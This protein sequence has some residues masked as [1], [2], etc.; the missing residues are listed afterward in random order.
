MKKALVISGVVV[1]LGAVACSAPSSAPSDGAAKEE[2]GG[3]SGADIP[4]PKAGT[5]QVLI[6]VGDSAIDKSTIQGY[7]VGAQELKVEQTAAGDLYINNIPPGKED[8]IVTAGTVAVA[9]LTSQP[10]GIRESGI[11]LKDGGQAK[12]DLP[13]IPAAGSIKGFATLTGQTDHAGIDV[14]IPGTTYIAKTASDGSFEISRVPVGKH[15]LYFDKDGYGRGINGLVEVKP[16]AATTIPEMRLIL[17]TG[18]N[19]TILL[20]GGAAV[21]ASLTVEVNVIASTDAVLMMLSEDVEFKN[22]AWS[23]VTTFTTYTFATG[24]AKTLYARFA[25]ANGLETTPVSDT[26][27]IDTAGPAGTISLNS[28]AAY[29]G[30]LSATVTVDVTDEFSTVTKMRLGASSDLSGVAWKAYAGTEPVT[31]SSGDGTKTIYAQFMDGYENVSAVLSDAITLDMTAPTITT[32]TPAN[33]ATAV[34]ADA[35]IVIRPSEA[36]AA[37]TVTGANVNLKQGST[38]IAVALSIDGNGDLRLNPSAALEPFTVYTVTATTGLTDLAGNPLAAQSVTTFTTAHFW[39]AEVA[40]DYEHASFDKVLHA[41]MSDGDILAVWF[42]NSDLNYARYDAQTGWGS[43]G[44]VATSVGATAISTALAACGDGSA[45]LVYRPDPGGSIVAR[46]FASGSWSGATTIGSTVGAGGGDPV[47]VGCSSA[48]GKGI[49]AWWYHDGAMSDD[50]VR[51]ATF[52]GTTWAAATAISDTSIAF[53]PYNI[54]VAVD[55]TGKGVVVWEQ[56]NDLYSNDYDGSGSWAG[57]ETLA[58]PAA[59]GEIELG[60]DGSDKVMVTWQQG[61][62]VGGGCTAASS[63]LKSRLFSAGTWA[64]AQDVKTDNTLCVSEHQLAVTTSGNAFS[65]FQQG[66]AGGLASANVYT[67]S[68]WGATAATVGSAGYSNIDVAASGSEATMIWTEDSGANLKI[69]YSTYASAAWSTEAT[70]FTGPLAFPAPRVARGSDGTTFLLFLR[71]SAGK[72]S[73]YLSRYR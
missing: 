67:S 18:P 11:E 3:S 27:N 5:G 7:V 17:S 64:A 61:D 10:L 39:T 35:D 49:A 30:S 24:G 31:L 70:A 1:V 46:R 19:A 54:K 16:G 22:V 73:L 62:A 51:A 12:L 57:Y 2:T 53:Q 45:L 63:L 42:S 40:V 55:S 20:E 37:A 28:G 50:D 60:V 44:V 4:P 52:N 41:I 32:V 21:A 34:A 72:R 26:I 59:L 47:A 8:V 29:A 48:S 58:T 23:P 14:Y 66:V 38:T 65:A 9:A 6:S 56:D 36:L 33:A 15:D 43:P 13:T 69:R 71:E 68:A 25:D